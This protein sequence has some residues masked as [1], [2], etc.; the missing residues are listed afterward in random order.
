MDKVQKPSN[1]ECYTPPSEPFTMYMRQDLG[2]FFTVEKEQVTRMGKNRKIMR[3]D[4][5]N[6]DTSQKSAYWIKI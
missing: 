5:E 4:Q 6:V 3:G 1:S 2:L